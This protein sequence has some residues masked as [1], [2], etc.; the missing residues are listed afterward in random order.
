GLIHVH[1]LVL[2]TVTDRALRTVVQGGRNLRTGRTIH[3]A[4]SGGW[5]WG[6][7]CR[8][9]RVG[10]DA[11]RRLGSYMSKVI[12]YAVKAAGDGLPGGSHAVR[13]EDAGERTCRCG[14]AVTDCRCGHTHFAVQQDDGTVVWAPYQ[15]RP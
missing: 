9:E 13:M 14:Q 11:G 2:G 3:P 12:G 15:S 6:P 1:A 8:A 4:T 7:Q 10:P 5:S